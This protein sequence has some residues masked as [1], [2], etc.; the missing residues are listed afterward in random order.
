[1]KNM[2]NRSFE[3]KGLGKF[4]HIANLKVIDF[5]R[6]FVCK[7]INK[8]DDIN[9]YI[10]DEYEN[11]DD[12]VCWACCPI[13]FEEFDRLNQGIQTIEEC[14]IGPCGSDKNGFLIKNN[15]GEEQPTVTSVS[16]MPEKVCSGAT[17]SERF[18]DE[19]HGAGP[20]SLV[21]GKKI[22]SFVL[23]NKKYSNP[24]FSNSVLSSNVTKIKSMFSS[25]PY[26]ITTRNSL[27]SLSCAHS[28]VLN[29]VVSSKD[30]SDNELNLQSMTE[31]DEVFEA[32]ETILSTDSSE[33]DV[34]NAFRSKADAID[35]FESF[36]NTFNDKILDNNPIVQ[37]VDSNKTEPKIIP[38]NKE[39]KSIIVKKNK[40]CANKLKASKQRV[41]Y[42]DDCGSFLMYDNTG[43]RGFKFR[44]DIENKIFKGFCVFEEESLENGIT[45]KKKKYNI[46]VKTTVFEGDFGVSKPQYEIVLVE[47][48]QTP[49]EILLNI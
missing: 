34:I 16:A 28:L 36:I 49:E 30:E 31:S 20:L 3:I 33:N 11:C 15:V 27:I 37:L 4:E 45:I 23:N 26:S 40:D 13:A 19:C 44:S 8:K 18:I 21:Y 48:A 5:P 35:K 9:L 14:F 32:L 47:E 12:Y 7:L 25:L 24:M 2:K 42:H 39:T 43:K 22:A 1:M 29:V 17:Y 10:F 41:S 38:I 6:T 46:R